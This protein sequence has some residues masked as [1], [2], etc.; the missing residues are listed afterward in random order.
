MICPGD[1]SPMDGVD[2]TIHQVFGEDFIWYPVVGNHELPYGGGGETYPGSNMDWLR[3]NNLN[4]NS[5]PYIVRS[6]PPNCVET[7]F[8]FDYK[9]AHFVILN[10]YFDGNSDC[11][12]MGDICDAL[13]RWLEED[14]N[15]TDKEHIFVIGHEP[16]YPQPDRD[17][18]TSRHVGDSLDQFPE[19]RDGFWKL[20]QEKGVLAYINGHTHRHSVYLKDGVW[21]WDAGIAMGQADESAPST[22]FM[23]EVDDEKV[24]LEVYRDGHDGVYDYD[25]YRHT[26]SSHILVEA[27]FV[28]EG[29]YDPIMNCMTDHLNT[30]GFIP[31]TSP[32]SEDPREV[33]AIPADVTD[34]VLV[35]LRNHAEDSASVSRSVFLHEDGRIVDDYGTAGQIR[36]KAAEGWYF[37]VVKHRNHLPVMSQSAICLN[38]TVSE[39]YDFTLGEDRYWGNDAVLLD[40]DPPVYGL[41]GADVSG[42]GQIHLTDEMGELLQNNLHIGYYNADTDLNGTV[43]LASE[44]TRVRKNNQCTAKV[45]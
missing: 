17:T 11:T 27:K 39:L 8:S 6:G 29:A 38:Y 26:W 22:F 25:D 28:L 5:L 16:A 1:L 42:D 41:Y 33:S 45:K 40:T 18:G 14:L 19:H 12:G 13:Y 15:A 44:L 34:W 9:N 35:E 37:I 20:L 24:T 30:K 4:G 3:D 43:N 31:F 21:Q 23:V 32:Y 36:L 10:V 7:T 2:W